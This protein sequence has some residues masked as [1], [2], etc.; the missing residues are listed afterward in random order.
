MSNYF[1]MNVIKLRNSLLGYVFVFCKKKEKKEF[2]VC[3]FSVYMI[4][5]IFKKKFKCVICKVWK[6][7]CIYMYVV[8][9]DIR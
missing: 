8:G 2:N 6:V 1:Y 5:C 3:C 7:K 4:K 9:S